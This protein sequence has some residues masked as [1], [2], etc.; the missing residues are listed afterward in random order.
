MTLTS[1][2]VWDT[3]IPKELAQVVKALVL[4]ICPFKV[5]DLTSLKY[6]QFIGAIPPVE[7]STIYLDLCRFEISLVDNPRM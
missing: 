2:Q 4:E 1:P 3:T 5:Q 7:K 6:K